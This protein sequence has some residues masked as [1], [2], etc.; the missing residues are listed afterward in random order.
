MSHLVRAIEPYA[1]CHRACVVYS[2]SAGML[3]CRCSSPKSRSRFR[4]S[5]SAAG[6]TCSEGATMTVSLLTLAVVL[7]VF[8][9]WLMADPPVS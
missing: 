5:P 8:G 9:V 2:P 6:T 4:P 7:V 3:S 1:R